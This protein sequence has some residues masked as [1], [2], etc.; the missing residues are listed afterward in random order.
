[1]IKEPLHLILF[2]LIIGLSGC[3]SEPYALDEPS[4]V[5]P[6]DTMIMVLKELTLMESH[7]QTKYIQLSNYYK[8][9]KLSGDVILEK[10][11]LSSSRL[12]R[13]MVYYGSKQYEMQEMYT[14]ILDTLIIQSN[15]VLKPSPRNNFQPESVT[16]KRLN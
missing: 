5:I 10:Y 11:K 4:D 8:S 16:P 13:S 12:E 14:S 7:L 9:L 1:M 2:T 15:T 3:Q 6:K